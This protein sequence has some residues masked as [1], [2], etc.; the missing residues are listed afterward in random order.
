VEGEE[1]LL[2]TFIQ[3]RHGGQ[4]GADDEL[5]SIVLHTVEFVAAMFD[6]VE[7]PVDD[8]GDARLELAEPARGKGRHEQPANSGM[9]FAVHLGDELHAHELVELLEA[10]PLRHLRGEALGI[11]KHFVHVRVTT[12]HHLRRTV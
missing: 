2:L 8:L 9:L 12:A 11:A 3:V 7:H 1:N 4:Q 6:L 5:R 10:G